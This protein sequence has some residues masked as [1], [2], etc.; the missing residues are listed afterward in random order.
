MIHVAKFIARHLV[1]TT[2][3]AIVALA[4]LLS[5]ARIL[6][7]VVLEQ[8]AGRIALSAGARLGQPVTVE[9]LSA[10]WRGVGPVLVLK[11]VR[12]WEVDGSRPVLYL[13]DITLDFGLADMLSSGFLAP[14]R[15][16]L[17]GLH[18]TIIRRPNGEITVEGFSPGEA[19]TACGCRTA[20]SCWRI[21]SARGRPS[22]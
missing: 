6:T 19:G 15:I 4:L 12:L 5:A 9:G 20:A 11:G 22:S 2:F 1:L 14:G 3:L 7:P 21:V 17:S 18:L 10:R 8:Y 16:T 13:E